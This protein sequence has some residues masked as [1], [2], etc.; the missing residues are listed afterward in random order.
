MFKTLPWRSALLGLALLGGAALAQPVAPAVAAAQAGPGTDTAAVDAAP[1]AAHT[2]PRRPRICLV[3]SGGGARG[4]AHIGVIKVLEELRV[5]VDCIA[6]TSMGAIVGAAYASGMDV[7]EMS[8][9]ITR[10][11]TERL[12]TDTPPRADEPMQR[13][14][15]HYQ[16]LWSPEF[17]VSRGGVTT[18]KGVISG[19]ALEGAL[20]HLVKVRGTWHFDELPIPFRAVATSLGS[21]RMVVFN[22]GEL[23]TAMRASMSVPA[24]IAP[25]SFDGHLLIDGGLVRN[26]PVDVARSMGAD[27]VI[28]VNLGTPLLRPDQIDGLLGVAMQTLGILTEQNV[29]ESLAQLQPGDVLIQPE[30]GDFSAADF[31]NL[32]KAVPFGEAAVR[33]V[34]DRLQALALPASEY[35]ALRNRQTNVAPVQPQAIAAIEIIGNRRVNA[36]V[37]RQNMLTEVGKLPDADETELDMRRIFGAGDFESVH[38]ELRDIDGEQTLVVDV[39]EKSWGPHYLRVGLA[40]SSDLGKDATFNLYGKLR[41]TWLNSYGAEWR[42]DVVLGNDVVL[43]SSFYQPLSPRQYFFVE[44]RVGYAD[45]PFDIFLR[46]VI[47]TEYRNRTLGVGVDLGI[48]FKQYGE[49][50]IG[51]YR[52]RSEYSASAGA[53]ILPKDFEVDRGLALASLR[54]DRLDSVSFTRS[55]YLLALGLQASRQELGASANYTK[56]EGEA[57]GAHSIGEHALQLALRGGESS[58]GEFLP[59]YAQFQLGGFLN[60]SGYRQQQLLGPRYLYGRLSYQT[61]LARLPIFEGVYGGLAYEAANM[62]QI[63]P[64]NDKSLFQAGTAYLAADTPLGVAYFGLGYA[65]QQNKAVYLYL[66]KPF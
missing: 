20:R 47:L 66:G 30:L 44:P 7:A 42:N 63:I 48:N 23:P 25:L 65:N 43:L 56:Y 64:T 4:A 33:K 19:V 40:L 24:M 39:T 62:P 52:G 53:T 55:G 60:M 10:I 11:T 12:F 13:K 38:P 34:A 29:R 32:A 41:S 49:A 50:R 2:A 46:D 45:T 5:P 16:P 22:R 51:L 26:L 3:L 57:R 8:E 59:A 28:A 14:A 35:A 36:E 37:I 27:V 17:G 58:E 1:S 9:A 54:I 6:G 18:P 61:R 31:D 15:D 21:G